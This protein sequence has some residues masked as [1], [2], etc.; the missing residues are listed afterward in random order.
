MNN[1]DIGRDA[2]HYQEGAANDRPAETAAP[3][4]GEFG[5]EALLRDND[6]AFRSVRRGETV[7][8][9]VVRVDQ[10]EV[11]VDIGLKSEGVIPS[12]EFLSETLEEDPLHVGDRTLLYVIQP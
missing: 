1:E 2:A 12:R 10:D 6:Y 8:G 7:E 5:M 9:T 3:G 11:L 4:E